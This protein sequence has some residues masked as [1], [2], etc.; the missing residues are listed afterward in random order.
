[1]KIAKKQEEIDCAL[2]KYY[3]HVRRDYKSQYTYL[4]IILFIVITISNIEKHKS[5]LWLC[6]G[7]SNVTPHHASS[8]TFITFMGRVVGWFCEMRLP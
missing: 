5:N 6:F 3:L 1:M 7:E 4:C 2:H 8:K